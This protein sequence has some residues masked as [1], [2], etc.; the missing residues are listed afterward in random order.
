MTKMYCNI[1]ACMFILGSN[2]CLLSYFIDPPI[3]VAML[4]FN[5]VCPGVCLRPFFG[6]NHSQ[7]A[8]I[9]ANTNKIFTTANEKTLVD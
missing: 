1:D 9:D 2:V 7:R 6:N 8:A 5:A 4:I 3:V